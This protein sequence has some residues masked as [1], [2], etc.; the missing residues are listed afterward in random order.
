MKRI[1]LAYLVLLTAG[2]SSGVEHLKTFIQDPLRDPHYAE[3]Q[4]KTADL[5]SIYL[6]RKITYA[7]YIERKKGLDDQYE[8]EI[9]ERNEKIQEQ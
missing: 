8:K 6:G 5:E 2:C 3:Y 9:K 1:V 4:Q 7:E